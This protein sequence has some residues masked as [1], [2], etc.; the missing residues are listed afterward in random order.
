M[1][2]V[3]FHTTVYLENCALLQPKSQ[4]MKIKHN[5]IVALELLLFL[6]KV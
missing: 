4:S 2:I 1:I 3:N 5:M 6:G